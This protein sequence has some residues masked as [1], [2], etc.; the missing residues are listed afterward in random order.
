MRVLAQLADVVASDRLG[1]DAR[2]VAKVTHRDLGM[3]RGVHK[4]DAAHTVSRFQYRLDH[5]ARFRCLCHWFN[6]SNSF[7]AMASAM[8]RS[9][10]ANHSAPI[11]RH[12]SNSSGS[13]F[14]RSFLA[15]A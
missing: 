2:L 3:R 1:Q 14:S 8:S 9:S 4:P 13:M 12:A 11:S 5:A 6:S 10:F 7:S 15:N